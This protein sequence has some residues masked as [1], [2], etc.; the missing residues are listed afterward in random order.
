MT[1]TT[2]LVIPEIVTSSEIQ[3]PQGA[4]PG[5]VD[6][7]LRSYIPSTQGTYRSTV[8][9]YQALLKEPFEYLLASRQRCFATASAFKT[10]LME[11]GSANATVNRHLAALRAFIEHCGPSGLGIVEW[12]LKIG[13]LPSKPYRD[14]H[15]PGVELVRKMFVAA[16][17]SPTPERDRALLGVLFGLAL[18]RGEV[19]KLGLGDCQM[20]RQ[21]LMVL[22]KGSG[23]QRVMVRMPDEVAEALAGWLAVRGGSPGALFLRPA[24]GLRRPATTSAPSASAPVSAPVPQAMSADWAAR[25]ARCLPGWSSKHGEV[26][27]AEL[28]P[29]PSVSAPIAY[30]GR[31]STRAIASAIARLARAAGS[32]SKVR[33]HGIRH[34]AI[35]EAA[36]KEKDLVKLRDFARHADIRTTA[37]YID[38]LENHGLEIATG[39]TSEVM[40]ETRPKPSK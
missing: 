27:D 34:T 30:K 18:R 19:A 40:G 25:L 22:G 32:T 5:V 2:D 11:E 21:A 14:T 17:E 8:N 23:G 24:G 4:V 36:R 31:M 10:L 37:I 15:G 6:H 12:A 16:N 39:V 9:K 35:T 13:D 3:L 7:W 28:E 1:D 33:P 26:A 38:N 20:D 29:E